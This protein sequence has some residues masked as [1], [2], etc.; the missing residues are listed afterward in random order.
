MQLRKPLALCAIVASLVGGT[1]LTA[2]AAQ[3]GDT[4]TTFDIQGGALSLT[5]EPGADLG[6]DY[7][8]HETDVTGQLGAV[9]VTDL[10]NGVVAWDASATSSAFEGDLGSASTSIVYTAGVVTEGGTGTIVVADG[11]ATLD[12]TDT[13]L[14]VVAPSVVSGDNSATWN[15]TLDVTM[16]ASALADTYTGIVTTSVA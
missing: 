4:L 16:P 7:V 5:V 8:A 6:V 15:P 10:R 13:I 2:S 1:A 12:I 14:P 3:T 11:S 9:T